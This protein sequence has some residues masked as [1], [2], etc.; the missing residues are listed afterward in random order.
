MQYDFI[1]Y[2]MDLEHRRVVAIRNGD[3]YALRCLG[4]SAWVTQD[5]GEDIWLRRGETMQLGTGTVVIE[6]LEDVR[7][8]LRRK[9]SFGRHL[10]ARVVEWLRRVFRSRSVAY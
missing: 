4:G 6:A 10:I 2:E 8:Q 7:I 1:K 3:L 9:E 5:G